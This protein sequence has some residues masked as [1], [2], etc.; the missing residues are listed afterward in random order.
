MPVYEIVCEEFFCNPFAGLF[1]SIGDSRYKL[2]SRDEEEY[3]RTEVMVRPFFWLRIQ[4]F[5]FPV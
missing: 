5:S 3:G 4:G 1:V 2:Y